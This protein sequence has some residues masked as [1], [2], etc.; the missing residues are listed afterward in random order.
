[1]D[2]EL[3]EEFKQLLERYESSPDSRL[4]APVADMYRK[5]GELEEAI[6]TCNQGLEIYPDYVSARVILGKCFYDKGASERA[7]TEFEKVLDLDPENMVALKFLGD[8]SL[9]ENKTGRAT[10]YY[11]KLL[12][13]DPTND[14]IREVYEE[15]NSEFEPTEIDLEK[16][17][18]V[19]SV[20]DETEPATMTLAGIYASQGYYG[21]AA[22][23][24]RS[25]LADNPGNEDVR[26]M[27]EKIQDKVS[28]TDSERENAF[29]DD[30][31]VMTIS[32]DDVSDEIVE[33]TSGTGVSDSE[34]EREEKFEQ[35]TEEERREKP[36]PDEEAEQQEA[37]EDLSENAESMENFLGWVRKVKE[38][39]DEDK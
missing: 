22:R 9:A 17:D 21:R 37:E 35:G 32:L 16:G 31:E 27:L 6:E 4:F 3:N 11:R 24:Y 28:E 20:V 38:D 2:S 14:R 25:I 18:Q 34:R 30:D 23:I 33:N 7:K 8:I 10:D 15:L 5:R 26:K 19:K 13:I 12:E 1:M 39:C 29:D 36:E